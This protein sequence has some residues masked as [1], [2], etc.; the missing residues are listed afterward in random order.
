MAHALMCVFASVHSVHRVQSP[1]AGD[2]RASEGRKEDSLRSEN[3]RNE[4]V[5]PWEGRAAV[6]AARIFGASLRDHTTQ[7]MIK[8][9]KG[10]R[11]RKGRTT[12]EP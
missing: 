5:A 8:A 3:L 11:D 10:T 4:A 9:S 6:I 12:D 7:T 2:T 1:S